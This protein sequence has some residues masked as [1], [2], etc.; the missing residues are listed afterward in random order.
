MSALSKL[1]TASQM[2]VRLPYHAIRSRR[3]LWTRYWRRQPAIGSIPY[4]VDLHDRYWER[5]LGI[6]TA[7]WAP[8]DIEDG[9]LYEG[10]PYLLVLEI[11]RHLDL[12]PQD[13]FVD[14]GCGKGRATCMAARGKAGTVIGVEQDEGFLATAK[15]NLAAL[16]GVHSEVRLEHGMAQDFNY[17]TT[18]VVFLFNSFGA[19]TLREVL[20]HL[21]ASLERHPRRLRFVYVNPEHE[22]VLR[23]TPW[24]KNTQTWPSDAYPEFIIKPSNPRVVTFWESQLPA[25]AS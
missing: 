13:V 18:T 14:L 4:E 9:M 6:D 22:Q 21:Q 20:D 10:T 23:E 7:G 25:Q 17:D 15:E 5:H 19:K 16:P 11:L 8:N 2:A 12:Q 1:K 3:L 24:M